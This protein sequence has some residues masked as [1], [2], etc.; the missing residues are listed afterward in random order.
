MQ[1]DCRL[2]HTWQDTHW[3]DVGRRPARALMRCVNCRRE[4]WVTVDA[5]MQ[6]DDDLMGQPT[7]DG[8]QEKT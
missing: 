1:H 5:H 6:P 4:Q 7:L 3:R 8:R 2:G